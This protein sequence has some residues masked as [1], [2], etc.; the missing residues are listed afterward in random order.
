[1]ISKN[2]IFIS[3]NHGEF[4]ISQNRDFIVKRHPIDNDVVIQFA[5]F[6]VKFFE[7]HDLKLDKTA[8]IT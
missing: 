2:R 6:A 7:D 8:S 5:F 4:L 3:Q 1:M